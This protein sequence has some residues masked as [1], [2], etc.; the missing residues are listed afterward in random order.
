MLDKHRYVLTCPALTDTR[1]T[2]G[3]LTDVTES[4]FSAFKHWNCGSATLFETL[5]HL[6][7]G[8]REM[9]LKPYLENIGGTKLFREI[10]TNAE[11]H[12]STLRYPR[13]L[14]VVMALRN[15]PRR[16]RGLDLLKPTPSW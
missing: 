13:P 2:N 16:D 9:M 5:V 10:K 3:V 15:F 6:C 11:S 1:F 12:H 7:G 14:I 8:C 4:L